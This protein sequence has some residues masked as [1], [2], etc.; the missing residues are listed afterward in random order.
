VVYTSHEEGDYG[1]YASSIHGIGNRKVSIV[2]HMPQ[3][4]VFK[5][6]VWLGSLDG[7]EPS[8]LLANVDM[9]TGEVTQERDG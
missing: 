1:N 2:T 5:T 3:P 7:M 8:K 6:K 9:Q 4:G